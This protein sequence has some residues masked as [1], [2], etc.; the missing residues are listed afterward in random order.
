MNIQELRHNIEKEIRKYGLDRKMVS[1]FSIIVDELLLLYSPDSEHASTK[2]IKTREELCV[3]ISIPGENR[4]PISIEEECNIYLLETTLNNSGFVLKHS[5]SNG[6]NIIILVLEKYFTIVNNM[7]FAFGF[8]AGDK[9]ILLIGCVYNIIAIVANLVIPYFT[10]TLVTAYTE[11]IFEQVI[12]SAGLLLFCRIIYFVFIAL[13]GINYNKVSYNMFARIQ[14]SL[15]DKLFSIK[16]E[17]FEYYG[18]AQFIQRINSDALVISENVASTFN[19]TSNAIYYAGVLAAS[20]AFDKFVFFAELV[21]FTGLYILERKRLNLLDSNRRH[22]L[23]CEEQHAELIH[24][25]VEGVS[26]IKLLGSKEYMIDKATKSA[27]ATADIKYHSV[28]EDTK[29]K[30]VNN[31]YIHTCFF[32]IMLYLGIALHNLKMTIPTALVLFNYFTII[33]MPLVSLIQRY[34]DFKKNFSISCERASNILYGNEFASERSGSIIPDSLKGD[35][36]FKNVSFTY[37]VPG[38]KRHKVIDNISFK[39]NAGTTV[40]FVGKS[41]AGKSTVLGLISGQRDANIGTV[42]IDGLDVLRISRDALRSNISVVSQS[43]YLFNASIK[44]NLIIAKPDA[45]MQEIEE[46]CRKA[47]ILD[48]IY[49][50]EYGFDTMMN[51]KGVRFSG[52]QKQRLVIA[53]SLLRK[54]NIL[55][56]DEA[57]SAVDNI[58]QQKIMQTLKNIEKECT[59]ILVAHRMSTVVDC[60]KIFVLSDGHIKG[61]GTHSE[62]IQNCEAYRELYESNE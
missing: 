8:L 14:T 7:K 50:T 24:E 39:I 12:W 43:P 22:Q 18:S 55:I 61:E 41:G 54:T 59:I 10:G 37:N 32:G 16:T 56:L 51:E 38:R 49:D 48:D 28:N 26:D 35:I 34:M 20:F 45:T 23:S 58:T 42:L 29:K 15:L 46:A 52:G 60:D 25:V 17:K 5:Y 40:A 36:E 2:I 33:S 9:S 27:K 13:A 53:R 11:N 1:Y 4:T 30:T 57:T 19:I 31:L 62:L 47:C 44:D 21:T 3:Q 6:T